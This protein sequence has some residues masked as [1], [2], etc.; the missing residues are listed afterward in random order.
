MLESR[1]G[2]DNYDA[3]LPIISRTKALATDLGAL[4]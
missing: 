1:R 3:G 4:Q 2:R